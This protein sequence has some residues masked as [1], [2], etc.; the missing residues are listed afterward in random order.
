MFMT[1]SHQSSQSAFAPGVYHSRSFLDDMFAFSDCSFQ[2]LLAESRGD[3]L[4]KDSLSAITVLLSECATISDHQGQSLRVIHVRVGEGIA[5][6][7]A[8]RERDCDLFPCVIKPLPHGFLLARVDEYDC[9][10]MSNVCSV[11][12][13]W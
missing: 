6:V 13:L 8:L 3:R 2:E 7:Q 10:G 11:V 12:P 9:R 5:R 1:A 4:E